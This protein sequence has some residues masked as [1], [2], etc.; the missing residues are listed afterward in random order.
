MAGLLGHNAHLVSYGAMSK[1][2]LSLSTSLF[3]FKNL[4]SHGFWQSRWYME[5]TGEEREKL[6]DVLAGLM[7]DG[8]VWSLPS[9]ENFRSVAEING[10]TAG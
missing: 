7:K 9:F 4:T 2:P 10:W 1:Q 6:M 5:R 3:I 8:K